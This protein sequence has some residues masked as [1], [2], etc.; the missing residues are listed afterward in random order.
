LQEEKPDRTFII[1]ERVERE[2]EEIRRRKQKRAYFDM[3]ELDLDELFLG[4]LVG[5]EFVAEVGHGDVSDLQLGGP[6]EES[7]WRAKESKRREEQDRDL[8]RVEGRED[9]AH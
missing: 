3:I 2:R 6:H 1:V 7:I 5:T 9:V 8:S 4:S